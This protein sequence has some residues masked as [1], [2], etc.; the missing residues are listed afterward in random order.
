MFSR[1][2]TSLGLIAISAAM[3]L[4]ASACNSDEP[5]PTS[6]PLTLTATVTPESTITPSPTTVTPR[7]TVT[8]SPTQIASATP[9]PMTGILEVRATDAPPEG[10][11]MILISAENVEVNAVGDET[12]EGWYMV[13]PG[14]ISFDLVALTGVEGV[15]GEAGLPPGSY[16]QLRLE[17]IETTVTI[18]GEDQAAT[19]P[20]G[21]L[22]FVGGFESWLVRRPS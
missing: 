1:F 16:A 22:R 11:S 13:V 10:V 3:A 4:L 6:P 5:T 21:K 19:V 9:V 14:P 2:Q 17:V 8:P 7:S 15:L 20:S 18:Q 12:D